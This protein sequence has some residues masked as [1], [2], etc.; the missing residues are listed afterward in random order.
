MNALYFLQTDTA[1]VNILFML[2]SYS[3]LPLP[4]LWQHI[5]DLIQIQVKKAHLIIY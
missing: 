4:V 2:K 1:T 3:A 5:L